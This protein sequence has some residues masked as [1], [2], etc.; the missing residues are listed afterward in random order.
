MVSAFSLALRRQ[1]QGGYL[2][3]QVSLFYVQVPGQP[4]LHTKTMSQKNG[5]K[6]MVKIYCMR[7]FFSIKKSLLYFSRQGF[8][9]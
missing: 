7:K 8:S 1:R 4:Q 2:Q 9:L 3:I 5:G 6:D